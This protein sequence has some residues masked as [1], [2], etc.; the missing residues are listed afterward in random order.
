M[1]IRSERTKKGGEKY[2]EEGREKKITLIF[3]CFTY[4]QECRWYISKDIIGVL[5]IGR[6][7]KIK[8]KW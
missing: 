1:C 3:Y 7:R 6:N 8:I 5:V 4:F 2:N